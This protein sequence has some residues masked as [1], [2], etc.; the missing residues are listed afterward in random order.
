MGFVGYFWIDRQI[1]QDIHDRLVCKVPIYGRLSFLDRQGEPTKSGIN[2]GD[3]WT[4][5]SYIEGST[6]A[7]AIWDFDHISESALK[8]P[9]ELGVEGQPVDE[10]LVQKLKLS[11]G[12]GV[13]VTRVAP[14]S[15][16]GS[17][18]AAAPRRDPHLQGPD[19]RPT[20][21]FGGRRPG[22]Q[23]RRKLPDDDQSRRQAGSPTDA[24]A[25]VPRAANRL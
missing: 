22:T 24:V 20:G 12:Q 4:F 19:D 10:A 23:D 21:R 8:T 9:T 13:V 2:V 17:A 15:P 5:R 16:A 6:K 14:A 1:P 18:G 25:G 3:V 11:P 7:T